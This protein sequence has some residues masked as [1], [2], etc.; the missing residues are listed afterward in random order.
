MIFAERSLNVTIIKI[1]LIMTGVIFEDN[2]TYNGLET[3]ATEIGLYEPFI[4]P[5]YSA[6]FLTQ[7]QDMTFSVSN[8][9][10]W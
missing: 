3:A 4:L 7:L 2:L 1:T 6:Y 5:N 10:L 8:P 9:N